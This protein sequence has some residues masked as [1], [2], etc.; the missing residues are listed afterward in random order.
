MPGKKNEVQYEC[1][2]ETYVDITFTIQIRRRT[3][4]YFFNLIVPCVLI[5]SMALL[6]FT[7]PPDSGEKLTLGITILLSHTVFLL[8]LAQVLPQS[9]EAVPI[10][11]Q[12]MLIPN[13]NMTKIKLLLKE[14]VYF[15]LFFF[16][17][18]KLFA[19]LNLHF[20]PLTAILFST[21]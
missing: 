2:P 9:S 3:L 18:P 13:L 8:R 11:G 14:I 21:S 1:C 15:F 10:L 12:N 4:Y 16:P 7:L 5:S 17:S 20:S 19:S 6:G